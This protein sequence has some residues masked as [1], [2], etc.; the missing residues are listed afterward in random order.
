[1][2]KSLA[3]PETMERMRA[4]GA[5]TVGDSPEQ[6]LAFLKKHHERWARVIKA[7]GVKAE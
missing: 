3:K 7:A 6:F 4:L 5:L 1:M 2:R